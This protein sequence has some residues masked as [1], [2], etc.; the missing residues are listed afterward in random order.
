M[1]TQR[2][3][4]RVIGRPLL[5]PFGVWLADHLDRRGMTQTEMAAMTGIATGTIANWLYNVPPTPASCFRIATGLRVPLWIVFEA[6]GYPVDGLLGV[7]SGDMRRAIVREL[8]RAPDE[9]LPEILAY[10][11]GKQR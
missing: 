5:D 3:V 2:R 8:E 1:T 10:V 7:P 9:L 11:Q 4:S 6:A